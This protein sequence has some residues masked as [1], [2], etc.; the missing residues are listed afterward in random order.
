MVSAIET[1]AAPG[2]VWPCEIAATQTLWVA[3][4]VAWKCNTFPSSMLALVSFSCN[5]FAMIEDGKR[6]RCWHSGIVGPLVGPVGGLD[7]LLIFTLNF[8]DFEP[9]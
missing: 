7:K 1:A 3:H 9:N 8:I 6:L 2:N 4:A 5:S